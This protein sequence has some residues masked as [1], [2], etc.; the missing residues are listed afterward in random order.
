[1]RNLGLQLERELGTKLFAVV[2]V[3]AAMVVTS[4]EVVMA[5]I[6]DV[7]PDA[8]APGAGVINDLLGWLKWMALAAAFGGLLIGA[9]SI[10][11]GHFGQHGGAAQS[12]RKWLMGGAGAAV[13][14]GLAITLTNTLY[15]ATATA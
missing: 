10:G 13:V 1:M 5:Q 6:T 4:P 2:I 15:N 12:G 14:A 3:A 11:V 7:A 9:I 8:T